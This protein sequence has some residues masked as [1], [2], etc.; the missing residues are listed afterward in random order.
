MEH[1]YPEVY[2]NEVVKNQG[3]F[4]E[5]L[6][7]ITPQIDSADL[8]IAYMKGYTRQQLDEGHAWYLT[9]DAAHL[10][11]VFLQESGYEMKPGEPFG[12]FM[13]N[14]I[15]RFYADAQ[16]RY[17]VPSSKLVELLPPSALR[18]VY[19]G[20]HDLDLRLAVEKIAKPVLEKSRGRPVGCCHA[21]RRDADGTVGDAD[22]AVG[23]ADGAVGDADGAVGGVERL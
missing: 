11:E 20:A 18:I 3:K 5:D 12:G 23:D 21:S 1:P 14:W 4:F 13:P 8:I 7:D 17:G 22:G 2:H 6:Q 16:W 9:L 19:P 15:G 10:K